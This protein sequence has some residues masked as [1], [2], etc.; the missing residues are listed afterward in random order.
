MSLL[1]EYVVC[2]SWQFQSDDILPSE[3]RSN[4]AK[5]KSKEEVDCDKKNSEDGSFYEIFGYL[6]LTAFEFL[7]FLSMLTVLGRYAT[8]KRE[9]VGFLESL[10]SGPTSAS[11]STLSGRAGL[12]NHKKD[13]AHVV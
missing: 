10:V 9:A 6:A 2:V 7:I 13:I 1:C 3:T 11:G 4:E 12:G 8:G 5:L